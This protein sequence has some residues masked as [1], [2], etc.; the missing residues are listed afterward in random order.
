MGFTAR[1]SPGP[2]LMK[3]F[4]TTIQRLGTEQA[5]MTI[6]EV[7]IAS[8][9]VVAVS[10]GALGTIDAATRSTSEE[11]HRA[12]ADGV[13]QA[14]QARMRSMRI[15]DLAN[16]NQTRTV[17]QEGT[18]YTVVSRGD[19]VT[20]NTGTA[21]CDEGTASADYI[22]ITSTVSW[23]SVGSRP[24]VL[25]ES[26]VSPSS[27]S[28][29]SDRGALAIEVDDAANNGI[30]G[31][32]VSG[33]GAGSFSGTTGSTGCVIFGDLPAGDYTLSVSGFASG[34]VDH[35]G[36]PPENHPTSVVGQSTNTVVLQYADPGSIPVSFTTRVGGSL[37]ASQADSI[38][39]FNTGMTTPKA[40]GTPGTQTSTL[41]AT[42]LFPFSSPDAV[43]AGT[44]EAD[45]P[46]PN[47]DEPPPAPEAIASV[48]VPPGGSAPATIQLP[49][50]GLTV[51]QGSS[52][53][54]SKAANAHVTVAD[55]NCPDDPTAGFKRDFT[56]DSQGALP[57]LALP[58]SAF[59]VCAD[60]VVSGSTRH[61][62]V[63]ASGSVEDVPLNT[64]AAL[65][66]GVTRDI[67][68]GGF[69]TGWTSGACPT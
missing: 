10:L 5:G 28:I 37:V 24:P 33:S 44:C 12:A 9:L 13:A 50:L 29:A 30:A 53:S 14:D 62:Y 39:V 69:G 6:V 38:M 59:Q 22:K 64:P 4:T 60:A 43:Y 3:R 21:S 26:I 34:L 68:L 35:D 52:T 57:N 32:P 23:P 2:L 67:F 65:S 7:L 16:L 61:N 58:Y 20:D 40:F 51:Y 56:T 66:S 8:I 18:A 55:V 54:S 49:W 25:A 48:T 45:N 19:F 41:T 27:G 47:D 17:T 1:R 11:R 31:V 63:R 36:N 42:P 15:S 46:N